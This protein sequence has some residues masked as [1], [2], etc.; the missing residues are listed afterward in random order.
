MVNLTNRVEELWRKLCSAEM[1]KVF[2]FTSLSTLVKMLTGLISIKVIAIIVGPAGVALLGQ[3]NSFTTIALCV[4][5]GGI[6]NGIVKYIAEYKG[7]DEK[8]KQLISTAFKITLYCSLV[9]GVCLII[10]HRIIS[11]MVLLSPAYGYVF[12]I[13]GLSIS[14]YAVNSLLLSVLNGYK[15]F[16]KY[17]AINIANSLA[18]LIFTVG[19][20]YF[21]QLKGALISAVT[22]Q[23]IMLLVTLWMARRLPWMKKEFFAQ[24]LQ[25]AI[26]KKYTH[27]AL[28]TFITIGSVPLSQL[29][30]RGHVISAISGVEAGWWE[31]MNRISSIY[32]MVITT[33]FSVYYLPR[34]SELTARAELRREIFKSYKIVMPLLLAGFTVIY[35]IRHFLIGL[36]VTADFLPMERLFIWQLVGDIFKIASW[37]LA[38]LMIAKSMTKTF[39]ATEVISSATF[40]G[41]SFILLNI[42]GIVGITQAY[43]I[44][45]IL[46]TFTMVFIFRKLLLNR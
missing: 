38:F 34:L 39:I 23:S 1:L 42:N 19:F 29:I 21:Y 16:K 22:Y 2:S 32:L 37:L 17:V 15:E 36:V 44:S 12:I 18:G 45:Y 33:S 30:L 3:L 9:V 6:A 25:V 7:S 11:N 4:A 27:Y 26:S 43:L 24:K 8:V 10:F 28:M 40:V 5:T 20:V 14:L 31:A 13:L 46:Y 35:L 41:L